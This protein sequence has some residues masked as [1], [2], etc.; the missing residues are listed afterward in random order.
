MSEAR[1]KTT[2]SAC[3]LDG[4]AYRNIPMLIDKHNRVFWPAT[5]WFRELTVN[6]RPLES[7]RDAY[8][9]IFLAF[10]RFL[11]S[12]RWSWEDVTESHL[13][14]WRNKLR[15]TCEN[16]TINTNLS[17]VIA[18]YIWAQEK[19][20]IVDRIGLTPPG[21]RPFPIRLI[22]GKGKYSRSV[23]TPLHLKEQR[24][25]RLPVPTF[26]E[27]NR[28]FEELAAM[29]NNYVSRRNCLIANWSVKSGLRRNEGLDL[30]VK[31]LPPLAEVLILRDEEIFWLTIV[32]KGGH[33][34]NVPVL[35]EVLL[36]TYAFL[37]HRAEHLKSKS[38]K[39]QGYIF[40]SE[41]TGGKLDKQ[42]LSRLMS[43]AFKKAL[44]RLPF[45][46]KR[47]LT[48]H[49]LRARFIS[50]LVQEVKRMEEERTGT[51]LIN[52]NIVLQRVAD[53][54]GHASIATLRHYLDAEVDMRDG[55]CRAAAE[56]ARGTLH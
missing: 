19:G 24:K 32:G 53:I 54:I 8:A 9:D 34:R 14:L 37:D 28:F 29:G 26:D 44:A 27:V 6:G 48:F 2:S 33:E 36:D 31:D 43:E 49:R 25:P 47:K 51:K 17:V 1:L 7:S 39:D 23:T 4:I 20:Y 16:S 42:H 13:R 40:A 12:Q 55:S 35:K 56:A 45:S 41:N 18:F 3:V 10:W 22:K 5:D 30:K 11:D 15:K 21:E 50:K 52:D 38:L 46:K